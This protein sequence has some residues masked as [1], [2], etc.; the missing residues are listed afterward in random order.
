[1]QAGKNNI[2]LMQI[3]KCQSGVANFCDGISN[4]EPG[5]TLGQNSWV[6]IVFGT[7]TPSIRKSRGCPKNC[8]QKYISNNSYCRKFQKCQFFKVASCV[9]YYEESVGVAFLIL[10][11]KLTKLLAIKAN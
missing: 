10:V 6:F 5:M 11:R 3:W 2:K 1:M 7:V 9:L 4:F 8:L